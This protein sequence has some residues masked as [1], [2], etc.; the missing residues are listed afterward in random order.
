MVMRYSKSQSGFLPSDTDY[1]ERTPGDLVEISDELYLSLLDVQSNGKVI[2]ADDDG[3]PYLS[4]PPPKTKEQNIAD[5][6]SEKERRMQRI[7]SKTQIWQTQLLLGMITDE[8]KVSL[9]VWMKYAQKL[10]ATDISDAPD[11]DWPDEP[12]V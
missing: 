2:V 7:N 4:D 5:A 10:Q 1:G 3:Y 6:K 8:D 9:T 11:V 12:S